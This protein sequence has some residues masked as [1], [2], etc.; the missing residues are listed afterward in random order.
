MK[1]IMTPDLYYSLI[2]VRGFTEMNGKSYKEHIIIILGEF[3]NDE[4]KNKIRKTIKDE[5]ALE[6]IP[7]P[8]THEMNYH[9]V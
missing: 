6:L 4:I 8:Y 9:Q 5:E 3:L 1:Y 2:N 7:F